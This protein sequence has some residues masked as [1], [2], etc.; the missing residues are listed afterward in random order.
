MIKLKNYV[1]HDENLFHKALT[2]SSYGLDNYEFLEFLGDSIL[3]FLI[4]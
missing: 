4:A 2:H 1:F 3:D